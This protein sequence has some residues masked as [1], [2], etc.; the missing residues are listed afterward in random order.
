M[1]AARMTSSAP[2]TEFQKRAWD[3]TH[4]QGMPQLW[5]RRGFWQI[6]LRWAVAPL[7]IAGVFAGKALGFEFRV[8]PVLL[9]ALASPVYNAFFAWIF[10]RYE[11]RLRR[12]PQLDLMFTALEVLA[13]YAAMFLLIFFTGGVSSPLLIFLIFHVIISAI[14][15]SAKTSLLFAALAGGGLWLLFLADLQGWCRCQPVL[16]RGQVLSLMDP[17]AHAAGMLFLFTCTLFLTAAMVARIMGRFRQG[18]HD[19]AQANAA[20]ADLNEKLN[21]LYAMVCA[22][23][24][25]RHLAPILDTVTSELARVTGVLSGPGI[26]NSRVR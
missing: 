22:I 20:L 12:E 23:G 5:G 25:E 19:L 4:G 3:L 6:K 10:S 15:F 26:S 13:D 14:Q 1:Q 24:T 21:S 8:L 2:K 7:M 9:I 18:V 17:P 16:Y 11:V